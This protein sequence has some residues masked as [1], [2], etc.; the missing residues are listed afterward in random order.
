MGVS[1]PAGLSAED[2]LVREGS[3]DSVKVLCF[4]LTLLVGIKC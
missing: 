4:N 1:P 2:E 3:V